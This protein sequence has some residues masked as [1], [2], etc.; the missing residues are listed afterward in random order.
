MKKITFLL[1]IFMTTIVVSQNK[2]TSSLGEY[3]DGTNWVNSSKS[4]FTYD[5][6]ANLT[7]ET[8]LYWDSSSSQWIRS[9]TTTYTYNANNRVTLEFYQQYN[10]NTLTEE[11]RTTN[12]YG[13]NGDLTEILSE[14]FAGGSWEFEDNFILEYTN[15]KLSGAIS[16]EWN[17][18]DWVLGEDSSKVTI[19]YNANN[20]VSSSKSDSWDGA[21]WI[22][23]ERTLYTYDANDRIIIDEGQTWIGS[24]WV[25]DYKSEYTYDAN[26]NSITEQESY[27]DNGTFT[28]QDLETITFNTNEL[29]S[30]FSHPFKDRT[31]IDFI[32]S[33]NG[34]VNKILGRSSTNNRTTYNYGESTANTNSFSLVNFKV[35]PNPTNSIIYIDDSAFSLKNVEIYNIIGKKI[36][37]L[38]E[39]KIN[40]ESLVNGVYLLKVQLENGDFA[41]K[42]II[43]N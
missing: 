26:G 6:S 31:G 13:S 5:N 10:D 20:K 2:L 33:V 14:S 40:V 37:T 23:S 29:M 17:G 32:F 35:Y 42:R 7:Q 24:N 9:Y 43:K 28:L 16:Y 8:E 1:F 22:D 34:I 11:S 39:N 36:L 15:N 25:S 18:S 30:S 12:T 19:T 41:T 38:K 3:F 27:L 4:E 21:N